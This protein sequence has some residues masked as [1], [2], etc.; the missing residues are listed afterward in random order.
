MYRTVLQC[1]GCRSFLCDPAS[2]SV[3][4][5]NAKDLAIEAQSQGWKRSPGL[6]EG[7]WACKVCIPHFKGVSATEGER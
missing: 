6:V 5:S 2:G 7:L 3:V 1:D 4:Y